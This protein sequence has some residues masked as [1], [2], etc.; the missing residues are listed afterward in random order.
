[1]GGA[2]LFY[3]ADVVDSVPFPR[4]EL[5]CVGVLALLFS[6]VVAHV[7]GRRA[8]ESYRAIQPFEGGA[9]FVALQS[10]AWTIY[11]TMM[12]FYAVLLIN[13]EALEPSLQQPWLTVCGVVGVLPWVIVIGSIKYYQDA[14]S[15]FQNDV[16]VKLNFR[17]HYCPN[18]SQELISQLAGAKK[19]TTNPDLLNILESIESQLTTRQNEGEPY[20]SA[21]VKDSHPITTLIATGLSVLALFLCLLAD[22]LEA[23]IPGGNTIVTIIYIAG[24]I[25]L[26]I[27]PVM[28]HCKTGPLKYSHYRLWQPFRG[29]FHFVLLQTIGWCIYSLCCSGTVVLLF[30]SLGTSLTERPTVLGLHSLMGIFGTAA[31]CVILMS[32]NHFQDDRDSVVHCGQ[33]SFLQRNAEWTVSALMTTGAAFL[34]MAVESVRNKW[35]DVYSVAPIIFLAGLALFA[36]IPLLYIAVRKSRNRAGDDSREEGSTTGEIFGWMM[37]G[38][39]AA[40]AAM[41]IYQTIMAVIPMN[42]LRPLIVVGTTVGFTAQ[43]GFYLLIFWN[44]G[45]TLRKAIND[46]LLEVAANLITSIMYLL[47]V[48]LYLIWMLVCFPAT[49]GSMYFFIFMHVVTFSHLHA[50]LMALVRAGTV[51]GVMYGAYHYANENDYNLLMWT[52]AA[53]FYTLTYND[54][55]K[56][57]RRTSTTVENATWFWDQMGRYFGLTLV[58]DV[59]KGESLKD[60]LMASGRPILFGF[61]PHGIYPFTCVYGTL[62][63]MWKEKVGIRPS[64]HAASVLFGPPLLREMCMDW[65]KGCKQTVT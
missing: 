40:C 54:D 16:D 57:G 7:C 50:P 27:P 24:S 41:I 33:N 63:S 31:Y 55:Y 17:K 34:F 59:G 13:F 43:V 5:I 45:R 58:T 30:S 25:V 28:V 9:E 36:S 48:V 3:I 20:L 42:L 35:G 14:S 56:T 62:H 2:F 60:Q 38:V 65:W 44:E 10:M 1:M 29:G 46:A 4:R 8:H 49:P 37:S 64:V 32:L 11:A 6:P 23:S 26:L 21:S 51:V 19:V 61:H 15:Q 52:S 53:S 47:P 22:I 39:Q 18:A 12:V